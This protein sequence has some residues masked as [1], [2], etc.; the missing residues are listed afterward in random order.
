[1]GAFAE[2]ERIRER[3]REGIARAT[4]DGK[5]VE[6]RGMGQEARAPAE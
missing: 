2:G 6:K 5:P 1:M 3:T 4:A